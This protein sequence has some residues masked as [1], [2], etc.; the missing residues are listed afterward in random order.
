MK[1]FSRSLGSIGSLLCCLIAASAVRAQI[2]PDNTLPV[3]SSVEPGCT[4]CTID[5]GTTRGSN[6]FHSFRDF[7]VPTGGAAIFNNAAQI[8][9]II[10]RVTGSS[11]SAIDG[12]LHTNGTANLFLI[13]PN[14]VI[15]GAN[16]RLDMRG[17][18]VASTADAIA[19]P[20]G[21]TFSAITPTSPSTLLTIN[22][23]ALLVNQ[24]NPQPLINRSTAN[25]T[26][27]T[28]APGQS[29]ALVGGEVR[30]EGGRIQAPGGRVELGGLSAPGIIELSFDR[31]TPSLSFAGNVASADV[32]MN[33]NARINV[34]AANAG[35]VL[36]NARDFTMLGRNTLLVAGIDSGLGFPGAQ[37]GN[38]EINASGTVRL[39]AGTISNQVR[40]EAIGNGGDI[41]IRAGTIIGT[42]GAR[43]TTPMF[44]R[45]NGGNITINAR[46]NISFDS[47]ANQPVTAI[48]S[49]VQSGG[50]GN[51]GRIDITARNIS[52][53]N[54][55]GVSG[56]SEGR[57]NAGDITINASDAVSFEGDTG[58]LS[59]VVGEG[60][61]GNITLKAGSLSLT[62]GAS[63][64][65]G[66]FGRGNAGDTTVNV[67]DTISV[68][69]VSQGRFPIASTISSDISFGG[70][71]K[72]GNI[73][74]TTGSFV[75]TDGGGLTT[76]TAGQGNAGNIVLR[77]RDRVVFG[78]V[79]RNGF[80]TQANSSVVYEG[81]IGNGGDIQIQARS[82]TV[83]NGAAVTASTR[84]QGKA[85]NVVIDADEVQLSGGVFG[86][87]VK[88]KLFA[89]N[90]L[91]STVTEGAAATGPG[92]DVHITTRRLRLSD[93]SVLTAQTSNNQPGGNIQ[94]N[95][96]TI[97]L[98]SGG[99]IVTSTYGSGNAGNIRVNATDRITL[100][101]FDPALDQ[102]I[103]Q[104]GIEQIAQASASSGLFAQTEGTGQAGDISVQAPQ[105][106]VRDQAQILA[107]TL[108]T[109]R[110]G[111]IQLT[112][113]DR[114]QLETSGQISASTRSGT[115]GNLD[116]V[117][118]A[119]DLTGNSLLSVEA[120]RGGIAGDLNI[121]ARRLT[122]D[123]SSVTVSN[124]QGQ[125]GTL[126]I[127]AS[128]IRLRDRAKLIAEAGGDN[129]N[130]VSRQAEI[131]LQDVNLLLLRNGSL[132]SA[133]AGGNA[134]GGNININAVNG[135]VI[136]I[137][138]ENSDIIASASRGNGGRIN[139]AAQQIFGFQVSDRPSPLSEINASSEFGI[140]GTVSL[141]TLSVDPNQG[142]VEL[143]TNLV[144]ASRLVA[145]GCASEGSAQANR[146]EFYQT[147][148]GGIA[149]LPTDPVG[150]S[151]ILEDLQPPPSWTAASQSDPP[152]VEVQGWQTNQ[153]GE[154][155]LVAA[156]TERW[157]CGR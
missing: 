147:G 4:T 41:A 63:I 91:I 129:Q 74:I 92:G 116:V 135:F 16:A 47:R 142:I 18:F 122:A 87:T 54:G 82:L 58:V 11:I 21:E 118:G 57:G 72:G 97:E 26:G 61:G 132:I 121:T 35:D 67:R 137:P 29:I 125:A 94:V 71:G 138:N 157:R 73:T 25:T 104:F 113:P 93:G 60:N 43:I 95:A 123:N 28:A 66:V 12:L 31:G 15:F 134:N 77:A 143:P 44:G 155:F 139:I 68:S 5:G 141:N 148:R 149:P 90:T 114:L 42:N 111:N 1:L 146:G 24:L 152:I 124:P 45:G 112:I 130:G 76:A 84:G 98:N 101:G 37:A 128:D 126:T 20:N 10:T 34:L 83:A 81:A 136:A 100:T 108:E 78:G 62:N 103:A 14:G 39:D 154:V 151:D 53:T 127:R 86:V 133:R 33:N 80:Q 156:P 50:I 55:S 153:Q 46:D 140:A 110:G 119:V 70:E 2:V 52:M 117:A 23:N 85:G 120:G 105:L 27:L 150:S 131:Q 9:N 49:S 102:K 7:S 107:S 8:Q 79:S 106:I 65:N 145:V 40:T 48:I 22:P 69:G 56:T 99:E 75:A 64:R 115:A 13:N 17:S 96:S 19:F 144:D 109:S 89:Y 88:G 3:N 32:L 36:I 51:A 30:L 38:I 6:L 59:G